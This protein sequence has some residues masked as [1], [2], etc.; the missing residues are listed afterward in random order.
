M[1]EKTNNNC[2]VAMARIY[3]GQEYARSI[4][5]PRVMVVTCTTPPCEVG[6]GASYEA[7]NR[8]ST[9]SSVVVGVNTNHHYLLQLYGKKS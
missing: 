8:A 5:V 6:I 7:T 4:Q 9:L 1:K 3:K 2:A